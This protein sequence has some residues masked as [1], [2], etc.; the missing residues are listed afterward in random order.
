MFLLRTLPRP[1]RSCRLATVLDKEYQHD[2]HSITSGSDHL[3]RAFRLS[4]D[5]TAGKSGAIRGG[6]CRRSREEKR[7]RLRLGKREELPVYSV[8]AQN[9][10]STQAQ[11]NPRLVSERVTYFSIKLK[12]SLAFYF[13]DIR[14]SSVSFAYGSTNFVQTPVNHR[15]QS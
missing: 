4:F 1:T 12:N 13:N 3:E 5:R 14:I 7:D 9:F 10:G 2:T 11:K 15:G 8:S 6:I